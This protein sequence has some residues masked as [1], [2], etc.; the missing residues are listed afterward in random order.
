MARSPHAA[1]MAMALFGKKAGE[2]VTVNGKVWEIVGL[3]A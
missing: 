3:K 2:A 1:P